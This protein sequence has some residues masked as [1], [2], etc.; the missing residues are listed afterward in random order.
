MNG[1]RTKDE[2][3][4]IPLGSY[5]SLIGMEWLEQYHAIL[6]YH[7]KEITCLDEEGN[8]KTVQGIPRVVAI[9]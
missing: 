7:N 8:W 5:E 2:L 4:I 6:D 9:R 1:L 3:K